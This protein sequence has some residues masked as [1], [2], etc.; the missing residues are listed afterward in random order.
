M[1]EAFRNKSNV[2]EKSFIKLQK[3]LEKTKKDQQEKNLSMFSK[4][5]NQIHLKL[6]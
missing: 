2:N 3:Q 6:E 5:F 1:K 4:S